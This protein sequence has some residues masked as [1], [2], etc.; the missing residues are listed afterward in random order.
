M[1]AGKAFVFLFARKVTRSDWFFMT[2][3]VKQSDLLNCLQMLPK[4]QRLIW[5][6]SFFYSWLTGK[7][8][9]TCM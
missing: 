8:L 6:V 7:V 4:G 3:P 9:V 1:S 5:D 2:G